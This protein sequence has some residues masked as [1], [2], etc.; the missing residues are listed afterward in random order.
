MLRSRI[1]IADLRPP[2]HPLCGQ[3]FG[4]CYLD[5]PSF[6][7]P[8]PTGVETGAEAMAVVEA[9]AA[10]AMV[11]VAMVA[12]AMAAV[13]MARAVPTAE[14][15]QRLQQ[16]RLLRMTPPQLLL[17]RC[18]RSLPSSIRRLILLHQTTVTPEL[19]AIMAIPTTDPRGGEEASP[20]S[21]NGGVVDGPGV[22]R[23][24]RLGSSSRG[25]APG[26]AGRCGH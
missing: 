15:R 8:R 4:Y 7:I 9:M 1:S 25:F 26:C 6:L 24:G 16:L 11:A 19:S 2:I 10:V 3:L 12:V 13:P 20:G 18:S 22:R 14:M 21:T 5:R 23:P 17:P